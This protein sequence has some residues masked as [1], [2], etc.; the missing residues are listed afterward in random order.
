MTK[1]EMINLIHPADNSSER[2][3]RDREYIETNFNAI[4]STWEELKSYQKGKPDIETLRAAIRELKI[5][6]IR[7]FIPPLSFN[8]NDRSAYDLRLVVDHIEDV[9]DIY[10][11]SRGKGMTDE[12]IAQKAIRQVKAQILTGLVEKHLEATGQKAGGIEEYQD[13]IEENVDELYY[14]LQ[15]E[16]VNKSVREE[17]NYS[18]EEQGEIVLG[19]IERIKAEKQPKA[20]TVDML[21]AMSDEDRMRTLSEMSAIHAD[22]ETLKLLSSIIKKAGERR[23]L[24]KEVEEAE[25][26]SSRD[27][28]E[29]REE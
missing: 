26:Q 15:K 14:Q 2:A 24:Q 20:I 3:R 6:E 12:E 7:A 28:E 8:P 27:S 25:K 17:K 10:S 23:A 21:A 9:Y 18:E 5:N 22:E 13:D 29:K 4:L 11:D 19:Y 16:K 1:E